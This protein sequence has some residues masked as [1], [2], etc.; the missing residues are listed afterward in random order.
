MI[1]EFDSFRGSSDEAMLP[2][3]VRRLQPR[4]RQIATFVYLNGSAT[5]AE[6]HQSIEEPPSIYGIRT[7]MGRLTRKGILST[8]KSGRHTS[9]LYYPAIRSKSVREL[10]IRRFI[11][12]NFGGSAPAALEA[13]L[14]IRSV[15]DRRNGN[16]AHIQR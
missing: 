5:V 4:M 16:S 8:R 3:E 12:R 15:P 2:H 10:A 14:Q 6:V 7:M 9:V 13:L 1:Q 11:E